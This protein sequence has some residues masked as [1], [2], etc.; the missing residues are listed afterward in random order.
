MSEK[1]KRPSA[2]VA[3]GPLRYRVSHVNDPMLTG[4]SDVAVTGDR[5]VVLRRQAPELVMLGPNGA[6]TGESTELPQFVC[7]HGLRA[8]SAERNGR[9]GHGWAQDRASG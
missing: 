3:L 8:I 6:M 7:G 9:D 4:I 1:T 5:I 2:Y